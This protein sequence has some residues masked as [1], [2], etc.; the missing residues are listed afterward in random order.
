[1]NQSIH[2]KTSS[3]SYDEIL[4][5]LWSCD[6]NH[7]P[8]LSERLDIPN[9]ARKLLEKTVTFEAWSEN[10]L[11]GLIAAYLNDKEQGFI[12]NV[13]VSDDHIKKGIAKTLMQ[14]C[15]NDAVGKRICTLSLEVS[16][17]NNAAINLYTK[18]GFKKHNQST[19]SVIMRL[20]LKE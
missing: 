10:H 9:Y 20:N 8:K 16:N 19:R 15:I 2:Y 14:H 1:M 4:N 18:F 13:S 3:A 7:N 11:I 6:K 5:H 17:K 12:T